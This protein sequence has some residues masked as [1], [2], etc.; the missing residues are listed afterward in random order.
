MIASKSRLTNCET[1]HVGLSQG[2]FVLVQSSPLFAG[3]SAE[4]INACLAQARVQTYSRRA[5]L[6]RRGDA[7]RHFFIVLDGWIKLFRDSPDGGQT[8]IGVFTRG[9][10]FALTAALRLGSYP[11]NA[12]VVE[13]S[14][15][16]AM[17]ADVFAERARAN[18][19]LAMNINA[20]MGD[21]MQSFVAQ[22]ERLITRSAKERVIEFLAS[23]C[24]AKEGAVRLHLPHDKALIAARL[25]MEPE[26]FS[27]CLAKLRSL[28]V[29][30]E[31]SVIHITDIKV[32]RDVGADNRG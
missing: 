9:Q 30:S 20:A 11:A 17:P 22:V 3:V 28:G 7:A 12:E 21:L 1:N 29:E 23:Q 31:G 26:T 27:R 24:K 10:P 2:D 18:A 8:V 16:L 15:L 14:R 5:T 25:G 32:L 6:F 19:A 4:E 13:H